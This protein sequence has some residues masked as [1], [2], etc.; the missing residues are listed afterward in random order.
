[1]DRRP[2]IFT[3]SLDFELYWGVRD[4]VSLDDYRQNLIGVRQVVPALLS[5]FAEF[6]IHATWA[7][8]GLLFFQSKQ[9]LL[10][11]LPDR[12][13]QYANAHLSPY[14]TLDIIGADEEH[15]PYHYAPSLIAQVA[16]APGQ[17]IGSHTF[18]H[19]YCLERGQT[20]DDFRADMQAAVRIAAARG[21]RP[22]SIV[23][24]RNQTNS[25]DYLRV[26][27]D[28]GFKCYRGNQ[29]SWMYR[30]RADENESVWRRAMRVA[31]SYVNMSGHN[32]HAITAPGPHGL[33]NLPASRFLRPWTP[34]LRHA[35]PL[36]LRR[37]RADISHAASRGQLYHLW[38][39]PHNFGR[40]PGENI[41]VL[42]RV[43]ETVAAHRDRGTME[44]LSM[45]E[46]AQRVLAEHPHA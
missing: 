24:P 18:C 32:A 9:E 23:F 10:A 28:L 40:Y 34:A 41:A 26:C 44:S 37:L 3:I 16:A 11:G 1:M 20:L 42:R 4:K 31:D 33:V 46:A 22:V 30:G 29:D 45:G 19:Y 12:H 7:T 5:L 38:W 43:L 2:A 6:G 25:D 27:A 8:V 17:E 39:H 21:I 35:E 15:D 36:R 13:P 14:P